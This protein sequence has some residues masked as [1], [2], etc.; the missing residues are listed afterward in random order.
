MQNMTYLG[1]KNIRSDKMKVLAKN[2]S[3][4]LTK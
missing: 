1:C 3:A 4:R 2:T